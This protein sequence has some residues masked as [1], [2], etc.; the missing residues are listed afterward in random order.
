MLGLRAFFEAKKAD[1]IDKKQLTREFSNSATLR[2][3]EILNESTHLCQTTDTLS[4]FSER[5]QL[6]I[7]LAEKMLK[8]YRLGVPSIVRLGQAEVYQR[9]LNSEGLLKS[10]FLERYLNNVLIRAGSLKTKRGKLNRYTQKLTEL[11]NYDILF[12][13]SDAYKRVTE[14]LERNIKILSQ[15]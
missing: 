6:S 12:G 11:Q 14:T 9:I 4:V 10:Q 2:S 15:E 8:A 5:L 1:R 3:A 13:N 7:S